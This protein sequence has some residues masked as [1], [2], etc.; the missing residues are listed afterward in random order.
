MNTPRRFAR[1]A[2]LL[3]ALGLALPWRAAAL[4]DHG[5]L[6]WPDL[7]FDPAVPAPSAVLGFEVG[8]WHA[9]PDQVTAYAERL[10]ATSPRVHLVVQGRTHEERPQVLL[11]I[12]SAENLARLE[13]LRH[14]HLALSE[15][16]AEPAPEHLADRPVV[17][18][19]GYSIHGNEASGANAALLVAYHLAAGRGA[20]LEGLLDRAVVLLDPMLNPDGLGRFSQWVN[21]HRGHVPVADPASR[22]HQEAWPG[23]RGN[24]YWFDLNRDWLLLTQPESRARIAIWRHWRPNVVADFHEMGSDSTYFFQP[25]D[26]RRQNPLTPEENLRLT[27]ELARHHAAALNRAG[28][29]Y[30]SEETFDDYYYGKGSTYPDLQ[31]A[32]G[33]LF[34]QASVRGHVRDTAQ[35]LRDLGF[36]VQNHFWAS[37]STLE[38]AV[39]LREDL[40]RLQARFFHEARAEGR[41]R[42]AAGYVFGAAEDPVRTTRLAELLAGHGIRVHGLAAPV[43]AGGRRFEP[44]SAFVVPF[45][46]RQYRLVRTLFE[47]VAEFPATTFYDVST[48]ALPRAFHLPAAELPAT[49]EGRGAVGD[50]VA[51]PAP[52]SPPVPAVEGTYALAFDWSPLTAPRSLYRLLSA[53]GLARVATRPFT[54][55]TADGARRFEAGAIVVPVAGQPIPLADLAEW[56]ATTARED[57]AAVVAVTSGLTPAGADLGSPGVLP[58]QAPRP[59]LVVGSGVSPTAA[60]ALWHFVDRELRLPLAMI[61]R[62]AFER[63][64][65]EGYSH[66][67]LPDGEYGRGTEAARARLE[68]WVRAG[69][70]LVATERA[71]LWIAHRLL[72]MAPEA[73]ATGSAPDGAAP[74]RRSYAGYEDEREAEQVSGAAFAVDLDLTHPLA[75]GYRADPLAVFRTHARVLAPSANPYENVG[76]Y[77]AAPRLSGYA[78]ERNQQR[79]AGSAAVIA[80]R[81]G[82]GTVILLADDP[83]FRG[84]QR[85]TEK[86]LANALFFGSLIRETQAPAEWGK[87]G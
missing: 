78:S 65:L 41:R 16:T 75:F 18:W 87:E 74:P 76:L 12:S 2:G 19:L 69:G 66:L 57:G 63:T 15:G 3:L 8:Q 33:I 22:E 17:V 23:G 25:G 42:A 54:A 73:A 31:G 27:R 81:L 80:R 5:H 4:P 82:R 36:A 50:A 45:D 38:G 64:A 44:G 58:V 55:T 84:I 61:E 37:F 46:Q 43:T 1:R 28:R 24:H 34:E 10:A 53:G 26:P 14:E 67:I 71:A 20:T 39:R 7:T 72:D 13:E 56:A 6:P 51:V 49:T 30:Y 79:I 59:L 68:G 83:V 85:G 70:V 9:R 48:W 47:D 77:T 40:L 86:L 35:G 62:E 11:V 52:P 60:G 21:Q 32:V 29:L